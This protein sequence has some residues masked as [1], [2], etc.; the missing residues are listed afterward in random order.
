MA[1]K[2]AINAEGFCTFHADDDTLAERLAAAAAGL[3]DTAVIDG[4]FC[5]LEHGGNT[6]VFISGDALAAVGA[7]DHLLRLTG[8]TGLSNTTITG[9]NL[10]IN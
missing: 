9:G 10:T 7:A 1:T 2:A 4:N 8:V 5:I 3:G 6:Y